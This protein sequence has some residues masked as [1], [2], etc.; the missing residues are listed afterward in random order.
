MLVLL[1][2][3]LCYMFVTLRYLV[4]IML[5][6]SVLPWSAVDSTWAAAYDDST[7]QRNSESWRLQLRYR[8][9][10][11]NVQSGTIL[12]WNRPSTGYE[13]QLQ[14]CLFLRTDTYNI[15]VIDFLFQNVHKW[16]SCTYTCKSKLTCLMFRVTSRNSFPNWHVVLRAKRQHF[17]WIRM[18]LMTYFRLF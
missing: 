4:F 14:T 6:I 7:Y 5:W 17:Q 12:Q 16:V 3:M 9:A 13:P 2:Y 11:T 10:G 1:G 15:S 8:P 18:T